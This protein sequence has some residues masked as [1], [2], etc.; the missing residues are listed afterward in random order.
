MNKLNQMQIE[1]TRLAVKRGIEEGLDTVSNTM[2]GVNVIYR[3]DKINVY[4]TMSELLIGFT[5]AGFQFICR[6]PLWVNGQYDLTSD[7]DLLTSFNSYRSLFI[8][9]WVEQTLMC[10]GE[11]QKWVGYHSTLDAEQEKELNEGR[12]N[13]AVTIMHTK[14]RFSR[15]EGE[16]MW[17]YVDMPAPCTMKFIDPDDESEIV[18]ARLEIE[19]AGTGEIPLDKI[20]EA[21]RHQYLENK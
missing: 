2:L 10:Q 3:K 12:I 6:I 20:C 11:F 5:A 13:F 14:N 4:T 7:G 18:S 1:E 19:Y 15:I 8:D 9:T 16:E 21:F 17:K